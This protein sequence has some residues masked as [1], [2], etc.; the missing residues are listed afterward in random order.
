MNPT[1]TYSLVLMK[2]EGIT[3]SFFMVLPSPT[4]TLFHKESRCK[5][6]DRR[7]FHRLSIF[8]GFSCTQSCIFREPYGKLSSDL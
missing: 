3:P 2:F 6:F 7:C 8:T 5:Y 4:M 1:C